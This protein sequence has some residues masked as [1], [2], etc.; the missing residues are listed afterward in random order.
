MQTNETLASVVT[1]PVGM[2]GLSNS[3]L[4]AEP[5]TVVVFDQVS[6]GSDLS[7]QISSMA[8]GANRPIHLV[9]VSA[10]AAGEAGMRQRLQDLAGRLRQ[11]QV[12]SDIEVGS[13]PTWV[14]HLNH[15]LPARG[16]VIGY[17]AAQ[18]GGSPTVVPAKGGDL[19]VPLVSVLPE[20]QL[21]ERFAWLRNLS[22]WAG[23]L[24]LLA[25]FFWSQVTLDRLTR[26]FDH[27][28]LLCLTAALEI[29]L[30]LAWNNFLS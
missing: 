15:S 12:E 3:S 14:D 1:E 6:E 16:Q 9:G 2:P 5:L 20:R 22:L 10:D 11:K 23:T 28:L 17:L 7:S 26:G 18:P 13:G 8:A 29:G 27:A 24:V 30:L 19:A 21:R 4:L 25:G